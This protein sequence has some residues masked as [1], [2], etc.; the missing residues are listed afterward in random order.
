MPPIA[1]NTCKNLFPP[2]SSILSPE[3]IGEFLSPGTNL[4]IAPLTSYP[5]SGEESDLSS[6]SQLILDSSIFFLVMFEI[7]V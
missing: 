1:I 5:A 7:P 6:G 3:N 2:D 4:G